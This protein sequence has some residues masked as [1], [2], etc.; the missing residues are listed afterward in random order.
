MLFDVPM[1]DLTAV[2]A[3]LA[4]DRP[5]RDAI[6]ADPVVALRAYDLSIADL[7]VLESVIAESDGIKTASIS[8]KVRRRTG[9]TGRERPPTIFRGGKSFSDTE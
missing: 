5:F 7:R 1:E 2:L 8:E 3:R 6:E 9:S 4:V